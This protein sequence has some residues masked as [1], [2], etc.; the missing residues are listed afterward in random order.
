MGMGNKHVTQEVLLEE[1]ERIREIMVYTA[2]KEGLVS[3]NTLKA[4]QILDRKLNELEEIYL[5]KP[6]LMK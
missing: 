5:K 4:S 2:L 3:D 1:I 6:L